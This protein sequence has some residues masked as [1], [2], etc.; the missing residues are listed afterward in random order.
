MK[1]FTLT[2]FL[3]LTIQAFTQYMMPIDSARILMNTGKTSQEKFYAMRRLDRYYYTTGM[4]DSSAN[5][6]KDM[7]ALAI[8]LKSDAFLYI[9]YRAIGNRYI[10]RADYNFG[11][12]NYFSALKYAISDS[13]RGG[14]Y[15]NLAYVY[16]ITENNEVALGYLKK[17]ESF[18]ITNF[19][20][21]N[22][23]YGLIYNDMKEP[24]SA[25]YHLK[26]ADE[27]DIRSYDPTVYAILP[28]QIGKAYELKGDS[29]LA[30]AYYKKALNYCK[31][32]KIVSAQIR[33]GN[34]Y[35]NFLLGEGKYEEAKLIALEILKVAEKAKMNEGLSN[36]SGILQ[37]IYAHSNQ[38]DSALYY[39][40]M[41]INY[42]DL[43]TNQK[44]QAEFQNLTFRQQLNDIDELVKIQHEKEQRQNNIQYALITL[45]ILTFIV[46]FLLLSRSIIVNEKWIE[47]LG[48][49]GLL[50]VFEFINLFIHPYLSKATHDS[51]I[52][53]LLILVI[54]AALLIPLHHKL[55]KWITGKM[56]EK[57]K[58]IRLD[59]ARKTIEKL[60]GNKQRI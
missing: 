26:R 53:M 54:I 8:K 13:L 20:F 59:A 24:D 18:G 23:L 33:H 58:K 11:L 28:T 10:I 57:N 1:Y 45:G 55:E 14:L 29:D 46:L 60:E 35:C 22:L 31:K 56:V 52:F 36:V 40:M 41:Q 39:A 3:L 15:Q 38:K 19:F 5:L 16:A 44:K 25:M 43:T 49:L 47:F 27:S 50:I 4:Y 12:A 51:P 9:V 6:Q 30:E 32:E 7:Y 17:A 21:Q 42:N 34:I 2:C 48:V 37:K